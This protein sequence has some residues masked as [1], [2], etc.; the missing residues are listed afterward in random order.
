[1]ILQAV[2]ALS[3]PHVAHIYTEEGAYTAYE[4]EYTA[5]YRKITRTEV[6]AI[7]RPLKDFVAEKQC[8]VQK[9][10]VFIDP[11]ETEEVDGALKPALTQN[12]AEGFTS[13]PFFYEIISNQA[14]KG[15]GLLYLAERF[16]VPL[17]QTAAVGDGQNDVS[18][19][20]ATPNSFA[21]QNANPKLKAV[22]KTVLPKTN[23]EN[24]VSYLIE[25]YCMGE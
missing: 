14:G 18:M 21:V 1:G 19:L 20:L 7:G 9:I 8:A 3:A 13:E 22:A 16:S 10:L 23:I 2:E 17:S 11:K 4:N 12:G 25:N 5:H 6:Q 24:A 15:R